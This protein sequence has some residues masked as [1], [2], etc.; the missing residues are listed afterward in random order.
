[1][2]SVRLA[3]DLVLETRRTEADGAGGYRETWVPLGIHWAEVIAGAG[4][5]VPG[6]EVTLSSVPYRIT[7][8]AYPVG[9]DGRPQPQQRFRDG[10]RLFRII[11]VTERD[12]AGRYLVCFAREEV[13]A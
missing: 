13:P 2:T 5:D 12:R 9:S 10:T 11:A 1:M 4:R 8:R 3:R 6:E 7:V